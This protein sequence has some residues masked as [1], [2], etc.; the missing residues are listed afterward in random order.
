MVMIN[1]RISIP[2]WY[3][4]VSHLDMKFGLLHIR[5][6]NILGDDLFVAHQ[7]MRSSWTRF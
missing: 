2:V 6:N 4:L 7:V 3:E 5:L 1:I